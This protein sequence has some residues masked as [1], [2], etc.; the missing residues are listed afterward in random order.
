MTRTSFSC[1]ENIVHFPLCA[2]RIGCRS[3]DRYFIEIFCHQLEAQPDYSD[4]DG[5]STFIGADLLA[6]PLRKCRQFINR[7]SSEPGNLRHFSRATT[8]NRSLGLRFVSG[9]PHVVP[10]TL[11]CLHGRCRDP[12]QA[13]SPGNGP[14]LLHCRSDFSSR[15]Q[16]HRQEPSQK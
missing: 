13:R 12:D 7:R 1:L 16:F 10:D 11:R 4:E 15:Q 8:T 9:N 5:A 14:A 6:S 3:C 2:E